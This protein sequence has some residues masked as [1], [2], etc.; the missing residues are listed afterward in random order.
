MVAV[1]VAA[2]FDL[3]TIRL[4]VLQSAVELHPGARPSWIRARPRDTIPTQTWPTTIPAHALVASKELYSTLSSHTSLLFSS[5]SSLGVSNGAR[6]SI[7]KS[8][9]VNVLSG[10][11][12]RRSPPGEELP[13]SAYRLP[14][15]MFIG[16]SRSGQR[17]A[18]ARMCLIWQ[19]C[20]LPWHMWPC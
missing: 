5:C 19:S 2:H 13:F 14:S 7:L 11:K 6:F 8:A 4:Y 1:G 3:H 10:T 18:F 15:S 17:L 20:P 9:A 16:C 12:N